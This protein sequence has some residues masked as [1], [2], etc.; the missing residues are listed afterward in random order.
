MHI[1]QYKILSENTTLILKYFNFKNL[2]VKIGFDATFWH[3]DEQLLKLLALF[4]SYL[5]IQLKK[6]FYY[7][8]S[9]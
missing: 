2:T 5:H 7:H 6:I 8:G 9:K 3:S 4:T 1:Q